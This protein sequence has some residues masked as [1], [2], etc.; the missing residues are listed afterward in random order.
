MNFEAVLMTDRTAIPTL[1]VIRVQL[2]RLV[3]LA[4]R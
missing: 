3:T 1:L 2:P 4:A